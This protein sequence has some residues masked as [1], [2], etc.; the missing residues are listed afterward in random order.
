M[1][2]QNKSGSQARPNPLP[3]QSVTLAQHV[4]DNPSGHHQR[5]THQPVQCLR[6]LEDLTKWPLRLLCSFTTVAGVCILMLNTRKLR[7]YKAETA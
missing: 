3:Q 4:S 7:K 5:Q 1:L 2:A 6:T